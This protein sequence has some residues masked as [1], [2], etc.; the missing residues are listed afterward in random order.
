VTTLVRDVEETIIKF[1]KESTC[2]YTPKEIM[3]EIYPEFQKIYPDSESFRRKL[4]RILSRNLRI[5]KNNYSSHYAYKKRIRLTKKDIAFIQEFF[6]MV[7]DPYDFMFYKPELK[8]LCLQYPDRPLE[9]TWR[10][11]KLREILTK[12][13]EYPGQNNR[14]YSDG[15]LP[16]FKD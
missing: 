4:M 9:E 6:E 10:F 13:W 15:G 8:E 16:E 5:I 2:W 7:D 14:I 3:G 1:L 11:E 12:L